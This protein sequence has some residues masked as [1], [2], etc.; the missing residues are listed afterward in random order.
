MT[1]LTCGDGWRLWRGA[2]REWWRELRDLA[3]FIEEGSKPNEVLVF[4]S[5]QSIKNAT[6][7]GVPILEFDV[8]LNKVYAEHFVFEVKDC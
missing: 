7:I 8:P 2:R 1:R 4:V 6:E 5:F 3:M